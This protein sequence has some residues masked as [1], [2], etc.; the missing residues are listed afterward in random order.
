MILGGFGDSFRNL[1]QDFD[2]FVARSGNY[3][4]EAFEMNEAHWV[5]I[6]DEWRGLTTKTHHP[7]HKVT[8]FAQTEYKKY[9]NLF[10][11]PSNPAM[12]TTFPLCPKGQEVAPPHV[13]SS[14]SSNKYGDSGSQEREPVST[15]DD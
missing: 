10:V 6:A 9:L 14:K 1:V 15:L 2:R 8:A 3:V 13:A 11:F 4:E 5:W 7:V 12:V